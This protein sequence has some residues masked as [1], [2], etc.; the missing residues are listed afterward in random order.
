L[1]VVDEKKFQ[2]ARGIAPKAVL[3]QAMQELFFF[4]VQRYGYG[5]RGAGFAR[6]ADRTHHCD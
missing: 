2:R 5:L 4:P 1:T 6:H 3:L